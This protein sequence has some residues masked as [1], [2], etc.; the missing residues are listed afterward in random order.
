MTTFTVKMTRHQLEA[1]QTLVTAAVSNIDDSADKS[2]D[3]LLANDWIC[4]AFEAEADAYCKPM[5]DRAE[6]DAKKAAEKAR[7]AGLP[8]TE[9]KQIQEDA[10]NTSMLSN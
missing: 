7:L 2:P 5:M 10:Y 1:L 4:G 9:I 6:I 8:E 3:V